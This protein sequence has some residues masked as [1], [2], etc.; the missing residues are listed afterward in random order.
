M[1]RVSLIISKTRTLLFFAVTMLFYIGA[2]LTHP[3]TPSIFTKLNLGDYMFGYAVAAMLFTNFLLSP[4]WSKISSYISSRATLLICSV[5]YGVGQILFGVCTQEWQFILARMFAG[6]FAG[7][8][9]ISILTYIINVSDDS[10]RNYNLAIIATIQAVFSSFGYFAGGIIGVNDPYL[11]VWVN[12]ALLILCGIFYFIICISDKTDT[13]V[14]MKPR[15]LLKEISPFASFFAIKPFLNTCLVLMFIMCMLQEV[16]FVGFD[17]L[18]NYYIREEFNFPPNYNGIIKGMIGIVQLIANS[19][20]CIWIVRNTDVKKSIILVFFACFA[21]ISLSIIFPEM[22]SFLIFSILAFAFS[23]ISIPIVQSIMAE[24]AKE[25]ASN[26]VI[27]FYNAMKAF[28]GIIGSF[29]VGALYSINSTLPFILIA[30]SYALTTLS[31]FAYYK[32]YNKKPLS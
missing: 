17:Q 8:A 32:K 20:L 16:S 2:N 31:A 5:G 9:M 7:G 24:Q 19:T 22:I 12:G 25:N 28:G 26:L 3:V 21:N 15:A 29:A 23:G 11:A 10:Q 6:I 14:N 4:F 30:I 13:F 27:G 18:F 1:K